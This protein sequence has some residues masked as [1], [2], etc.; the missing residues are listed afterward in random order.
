M[1]SLAVLIINHLW[2]HK[3]GKMPSK[4]KSIGLEIFN[5]LFIYLYD[6]YTFLILFLEKLCISQNVSRV[7]GKQ[8]QTMYV[9]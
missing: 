8:K 4:V 7:H 3:S 6:S 5:L 2:I 9:E 1:E